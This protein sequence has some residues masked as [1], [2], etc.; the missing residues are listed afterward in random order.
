MNYKK[1]ITMTVFFQA[2][3]IFSM[4]NKVDLKKFLS[5]GPYVNLYRR[6]ID[7]EHI[8]SIPGEN[9]TLKLIDK[10]NGHQAKSITA[11]QINEFSSELID[12]LVEG[13]FEVT[14]DNNNFFLQEQKNIILQRYNHIHAL[15]LNDS[16]FY[17]D[18]LLKGPEDSFFNNYF[19]QQ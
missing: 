7:A 14:K 9:F 18:S 12:N 11:K 6:N 1:I 15:S 10:M 16:D 8:S 3:S 17:Y 19:I 5:N 2:I 4:N 13:E